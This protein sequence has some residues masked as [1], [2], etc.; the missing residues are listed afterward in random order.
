MKPLAEF[1]AR[2]ATKNGLAKDG[3]QAWCKMCSKEALRSWMKANKSHFL[4]WQAK[5]RHKNAD[6]IRAWVDAHREEL[7]SA[8]RERR[9]KNPDYYRERAHSWRCRNREKVAQTLRR[10]A[11]RHPDKIRVK[12]QRRRARQANL[13]NTLSV[14]QWRMT[15]GLFRH[16]C[17]YC[18]KQ[19]AASGM[20]HDHLIAL[21]D[22][23]GY[24]MGNIVPSCRDCN[25][26]KLDR[27]YKEW[28]RKKGFP[29]QPL[30]DRL[31][32]LECLASEPT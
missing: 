8:D 19:V 16:T 27:S 10:Y 4:Q 3:F 9:N 18:G 15:V 32:S 1:Y 11:L 29:I 5:N 13:P 21:A 30:Q 26:S 23:G 28:M 6:K 22:G 14:E 17:A 24:V 25:L 2:K 31:V 7:K 12:K 20:E